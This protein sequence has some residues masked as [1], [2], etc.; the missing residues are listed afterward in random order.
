MISIWRQSVKE[1]EYTEAL[2]LNLKD[3]EREGRRPLY[4]QSLIGRFPQTTIEIE[5]SFPP[6]DYFDTGGFFMVS[7]HLKLELEHFGVLAE[8]FPVNSLYEGK[9]YTKKDYYFANVR[10]EVEC[11]D[12]VNGHYTHWQKAG[13]THWV[14]KI[15]KLVIDES[16]A[17]GHHLFFVGRLSGPVFCASEE[18]QKSVREKRFTGIDFIDPCRWH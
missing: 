12:E 7:E 9:P 11:V 1:G 17:K 5:S 14:D 16:R 8:F 15:I 10:D 18:L 2:V 3:F 13:W 4:Y 6:T